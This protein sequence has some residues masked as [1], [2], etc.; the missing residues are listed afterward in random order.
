MTCE[1]QRQGDEMFCA[2]CDMRWDFKS[3][4]VE[5]GKV[6]N[7]PS[8]RDMQRQ[9]YAKA[10]LGPHNDNHIGRTMMLKLRDHKWSQASKQERQ[11]CR[12]QAEAVLS[13]IDRGH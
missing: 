6:R 12:N 4:S 2:H 11:E 7:E 9:R 10:I 8:E 1:A 5:C 13:E 3:D